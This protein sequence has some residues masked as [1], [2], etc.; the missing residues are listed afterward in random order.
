MAPELLAGKPASTRSDIYSLGVVLFQLLIGDLTH[1]LTTDW[2]RKIVDPLLREDLEKCFAGN[3]EERFAQAAELAENCRS[4]EQRK[5][6]LTRRQADMAALANRKG[7]QKQLLFAC[8]VLV[9]LVVGGVLWNFTRPFENSQKAQA[10]ELYLKA[11]DHRTKAN[12]DDTE[13]AI[14][15]YLQATALYPKFPGAHVGLANAYL[16]KDSFYQPGQDWSTR[17]M[18]EIEKAFQID[19]NSAEAYTARASAYF[20]P[21][22][23]WNWEKAI[24]D[25]RHAISLNPKF[26]D[27]HQVLAY[28]YW[29][30]GM[31][32]EVI[33]EAQAAL[34]I[35]TNFPPALGDWCFALIYKQQYAKALEIVKQSSTNTVTWDWKLALCYYYL[36]QTNAAWSVLEEAEKRS[37]GKPELINVPSIQAILAARAGNTNLAMEKINEVKNSD[38]FAHRHH[39]YHHI[40]GA[41]AIM[42]DKTNALEWLKKSAAE[43]YPC[44]PCFRDDPI[45]Q[46]LHGDPAFEAFMAE[47]KRDFDQRQAFISSIKP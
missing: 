43:G 27:A 44:Y 25:L 35:K 39:S 40:S 22:N 36:D 11:E 30:L 38:Y 41:Y 13:R 20:R 37:R 18:D 1:P 34:N 31:L 4:F 14:E 23:N 32:D 47:Q 46:N 17:A 42:G 10:H 6:E 15:E 8:A 19:R 2:S 33:T 7:R 3:P 29:H 16:W 12:R 5:A 21:A 28:V 45:L 9:L 26:A 24:P